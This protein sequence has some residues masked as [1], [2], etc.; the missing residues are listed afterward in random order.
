[1]SANLAYLTLIDAA[2]ILIQK[3]SLHN[4]VFFRRGI[5]VPS[6]SCGTNAVMP[7]DNGLMAK[8]VMPVIL[9]VVFQIVLDT[10]SSKCVK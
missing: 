10:Y 2:K 5:H 9:R 3:I 4:M 8:N 6:K 7:N 1:M